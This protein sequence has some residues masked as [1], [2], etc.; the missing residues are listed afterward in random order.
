MK[1]PKEPWFYRTRDDFPVWKQWVW[2]IFGT[3]HENKANG[4][5]I[6]AYWFRGVYYVTKCEEL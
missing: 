5:F 6:R 4:Y 2:I 3:R 1:H